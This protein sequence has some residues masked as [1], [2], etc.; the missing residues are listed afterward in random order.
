MTAFN[1]INLPAKIEAD[2]SVTLLRDEALEASAL[3]ARVASPVENEQAVEAQRKL[4]SYL[5][6]IEDS[7]V[8]VKAPLLELTRKIDALAKELTAD[9]KHEMDR[10]SRIVGDYQALLESKARAAEAAKVAELNDIERER[11]EALAAASSLEEQDRIHQE[12]CDRV[13][14]LSPAH[15]THKAEGQ[16]VRTS[17]HVTVTNMHMLYLAHPGCVKMEA[18]LTEIKALLDAGVKVAG[19]NAQR[20][21]KAGVRV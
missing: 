18:R 2:A 21:T 8:A 10:L 6:L 13:A 3:I 4:A 9:A 12:F 19:V 20:V 7:R 16:T 1:P 14:L 11:Q 17:W 15:T 5:K